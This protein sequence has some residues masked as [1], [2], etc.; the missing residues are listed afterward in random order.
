MQP[1]TVSIRFQSLRNLDRL[2]AK[3]EIPLTTKTN[4]TSSEMLTVTET[5]TA[6]NIGR[7]K[8]YKLLKTGRLPVRCVRVGETWRCSRRDVE[9][10]CH[11][12]PV[13]TEAAAPEAA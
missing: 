7:T 4:S 12:E 13:I 5:L 2:R 11:G 9:R 3:K 8:F 10:Y 1:S 6:L